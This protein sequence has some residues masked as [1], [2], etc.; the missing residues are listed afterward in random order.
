MPKN[1]NKGNPSLSRDDRR[2][3]ELFEDAQRQFHRYQEI[4]DVTAVLAS[5]ETAEPPIP[6]WNSPLTL[7]L[8]N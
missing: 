5:P 2:A 1:V 4:R 8:R 6:N 7:V 3:L